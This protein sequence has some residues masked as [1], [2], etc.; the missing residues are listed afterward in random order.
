M[1]AHHANPNLGSCDPNVTLHEQQLSE[2]ITPAAHPDCHIPT[3][4]PVA[5][6]ARSAN[7]N[8]ALTN[9]AGAVARD[10]ALLN[11]LPKT[12]AAE[13]RQRFTS[14]LVALLPDDCQTAIKDPWA[15]FTT[16][17]RCVLVYY[18]LSSPL[19][20]PLSENEEEIPLRLA[21]AFKNRKAEVARYNHR[22]H[23]FASST[24]LLPSTKGRKLAGIP[25]IHLPKLA[26]EYPPRAF[27]IYESGV[28][29]NIWKMHHKTAIY[30]DKRGGWMPFHEL[31]PSKLQHIVGEDELVIIRDKHTD[32]IICLVTRNFCEK[33][34]LL[35]WVSR[36]ILENTEI[37]KSVRVCDPI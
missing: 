32:E 26:E 17:C 30:P 23:H 28:I 37:Q 15:M 3:F 25:T 7:I 6:M 19:L 29:H 35:E 34:G 11:L 1:M 31:D 14:A 16:H 5:P 18:F 21:A 12:Y 10:P 24:G 2:I 8:I 27:D 4:H 13:E 20:T 22:R 9:L 36:T 33:P